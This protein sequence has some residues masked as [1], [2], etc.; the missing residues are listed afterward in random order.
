MLE[1]KKKFIESN[2]GILKK[3]ESKVG[4]ELRRKLNALRIKMNTISKKL[5]KYGKI[6]KI[7]MGAT[8]RIYYEA[9]DGSESE[10]S[11]TDDS[12]DF[13]DDDIE[14]DESPKTKNE[15]FH[16]VGKHYAPKFSKVVR[17][18]GKNISVHALSL[19][20]SKVDDSD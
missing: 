14:E 20:M 18:S 16:S 2:K 8:N 9:S 1:R 5:L 7:P 11:A 17:P 3:D 6:G 10:S 4:I 15:P 13:D 19:K 12:D